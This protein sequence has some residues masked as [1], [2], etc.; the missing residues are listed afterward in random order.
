[1]STSKFL[2]ND[3]EEQN[4]EDERLSNITD[5]VCDSD[6]NKFKTLYNQ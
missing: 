2:L 3:A 4:D 6:E 5:M 1:M